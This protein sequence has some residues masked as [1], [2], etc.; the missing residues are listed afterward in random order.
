MKNGTED[1]KNHIAV[2]KTFTDTLEVFIKFSLTPTIAA[3]IQIIFS[4]YILKIQNFYSF[5]LIASGACLL[6]VI[7]YFYGIN[8]NILATK[9]FYVDNELIKN[10]NIN[11]RKGRDIYYSGRKKIWQTKRTEEIFQVIK[12]HSVIGA[13]ES[14]YHTGTIALVN[15]WIL[16]GYF[17]LREHLKVPAEQFLSYVLYAGLIMAPILRISAFIPEAQQCFIAKNNI[18][19]FLQSSRNTISHFNQ[20]FPIM[21]TTRNNDETIETIQ[22]TEKVA[23]VGSSGS[24][25]TTLLERIIGFRANDRADHKEISDN[26]LC[27]RYLSDT[28]VFE[29]GS[30]IEIFHGDYL[31]ALNTSKKFKIFQDFGDEKFKNFVMRAIE[32]NGEPFSLGERQRLNLIS[33]LIDRPDVLI[34]DEALS[35]IDEESEKDIIEILINEAKITLIY[36]GHRTSI[37]KLFQ[38]QIILK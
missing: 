35:G 8:F 24:G 26:V 6:I 29:K 27:I 20:G 30:V 17:V 38:R 5:I 22:Q 12:N 11:M 16:L 32:Q 14:L 15:F 33:A 23:I 28:P 4:L 13:L 37:Q 36:V 31:K 21:F 19:N 18:D 9:R 34:L 1:I 3:F 10:N 25:K 7:V 2:V